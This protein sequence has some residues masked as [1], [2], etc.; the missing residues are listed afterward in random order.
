MEYIINNDLFKIKEVVGVTDRD[1]YKELKGKR[2]TDSCTKH[3][4]HK[5]RRIKYFAGN[6]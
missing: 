4:K 6:P 2:E 5:K 1:K 3:N